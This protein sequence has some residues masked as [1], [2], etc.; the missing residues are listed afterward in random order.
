[1]PHRAQNI[2]ISIHEWL[3]KDMAFSQSFPSRCSYRRNTVVTQRRDFHI[4]V[5]PAKRF[6]NVTSERLTP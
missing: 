3:L 5:T 1:M 4:S 6:R 2:L